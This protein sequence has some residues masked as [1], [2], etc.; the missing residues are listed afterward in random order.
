VYLGVEMKKQEFI[1]KWGYQA[2]TGYGSALFDCREQL[3]MDLDSV[4][5]EIEN[6]PKV[7]SRKPFYYC[8][9]SDEICNSKPCGKWK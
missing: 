9:E 3:R 5:S 7:C 8:Y 2:G 1:N 6:T 4:I